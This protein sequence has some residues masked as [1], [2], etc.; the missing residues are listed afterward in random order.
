[1]RAT[2]FEHRG[3]E[4]VELV[5]AETA[6]GA[7]LCERCGCREDDIAKNGVAEDEEGG[8]TCS[9]S[10]L[11]APGSQASVKR[12]LCGVEFGRFDCGFGWCWFAERWSFAAFDGELR[13]RLAYAACWFVR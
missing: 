13:L 5:G 2:E 6:D 4:A 10:L 7:E 12:G 1:M 3:A 9:V 8:K 11:L